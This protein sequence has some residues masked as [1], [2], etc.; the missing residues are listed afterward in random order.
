MTFSSG[1]S[2]I[3]QHQFAGLRAAYTHFVELL[4]CAREAFM[5]R[6][7]MNAVMPPEPAPGF[8]S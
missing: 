7:M 4:A 1:T 6:L 8:R 3:F 5:P 2:A